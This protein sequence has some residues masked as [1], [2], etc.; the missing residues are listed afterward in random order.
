MTLGIRI[1]LPLPLFLFTALITLVNIHLIENINTLCSLFV[2]ILL[3]VEIQ[4]FS[5]GQRRLHSSPERLPLNKQL[6]QYL[7]GNHFIY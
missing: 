3:F 5:S 2:L 6:V 7:E 4:R 1:S